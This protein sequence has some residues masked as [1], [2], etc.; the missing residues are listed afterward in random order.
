VVFRRAADRYMLVVNAANVEKDLLWL[1][2]Q[3]PGA[4]SLRDRSDEYALLALQGPA[5]QAILQG[6][7]PVDLAAIRYYHFADT[8]VDGHHA[9]V[10]RTGY[11]GEDGFE[12]FVAP[13]RA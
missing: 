10:S 11:T 2:E 9:T 12:I 5:A 6:L 1:S 8:E 7:T 13:D 4:C 3:S